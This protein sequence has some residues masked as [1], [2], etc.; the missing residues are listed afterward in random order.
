MKLC[1]ESSSQLRPVPK[2]NSTFEYLIEKQGLKRED[3]GPD[4]FEKYFIK[5]QLSAE[6]LQSTLDLVKVILK[7]FSAQEGSLK[8]DSLRIAKKITV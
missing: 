3:L 7:Y 8:D 2:I 4:D 1:V 6:D 5:P